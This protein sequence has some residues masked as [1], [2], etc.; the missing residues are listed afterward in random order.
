MLQGS[1]LWITTIQLLTDRTTAAQLVDQDPLRLL[2]FL[3][4]ANPAVYNAINAQAAL[5]APPINL[6]AL[7]HNVV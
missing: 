5:Q 7:M 1:H 4:M 2:L 3:K 6:D